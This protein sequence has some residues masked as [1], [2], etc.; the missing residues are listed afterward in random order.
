VR[1]AWAT[2]LTTYTWLPPT[3]GGQVFSEKWLHRLGLRGDPA[4]REFGAAR[5]PLFKWKIGHEDRE[6]CGPPRGEAS[7]SALCS[8]CDGDHAG[9][10]FHFA[11]LV[12]SAAHLLKQQ[13]RRRYA[14]NGFAF[15]PIRAV[16]P[17]WTHG[18]SRVCRTGGG[19][20][21]TPQPDERS[22]APAR[23]PSSCDLLITRRMVCQDVVI[24]HQ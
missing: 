1:S 15:V 24:G 11:D 18:N 13:S 14:A 6:V 3:V 20:L 8:E 7:H 4:L 10:D 5:K 23:S 2:P 16:P 12:L 9:R 21:P 22:I 19:F 17:P